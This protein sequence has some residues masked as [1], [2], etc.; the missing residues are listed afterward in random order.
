MVSRKENLPVFL[1]LFAII[2]R[3]KITKWNF[4]NKIN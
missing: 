1:L 4:T 3:D 2:S